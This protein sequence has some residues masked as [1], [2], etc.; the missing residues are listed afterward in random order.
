MYL[1]KKNICR[2][3]DWKEKNRQI[4][5]LRLIETGEKL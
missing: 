4:E 1:I 2:G 3:L 5:T